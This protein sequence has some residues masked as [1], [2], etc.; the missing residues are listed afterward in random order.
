M[1][2]IAAPAGDAGTRASTPPRAIVVWPIA[3][4]GAAAA[5]TSVA[6]AL[7]NRSIGLEL[8]EPLVVALLH[9]S[10]TVAYVAC[11]LVAWVAR[12]TSRFGP[13][14]VVAGAVNFLTSLSWSTNE[15]VYTLGQTLDLVAP[16]VFLHAF[17]A[18]PTGRLRTRLERVVIGA[19][20]SIAVSFEIVRMLLGEFGPRNLLEVH[21][22]VALSHE[23]RRVQLVAI[24]AACLWGVVVLGVRRRRAGPPLRR[25]LDLLVEAF[26]LSLVLIAFLLLSLVVGTPVIAE[27]RWA[28]FV[29]LSLAP[30]AFLVGLLDARLARADVGGLVVELR[31]NPVPHELRDAVARALRDDSLELAFW[32][33]EY[34]VYADLDG[35]TVDVRAAGRA[36]T[37]I[38]RDDDSPVAALLHDP[39]LCDEPELLDAVAAA[40]AMAL[41]NARL[42]AELRARLDELRQS[43]ARIVEAGQKERQ[44]LERN[45]HDGAQQRLVA[46]S[47]ELSRLEGRLA[48]DAEAVAR[49]ERAQGEIAASLDALRELAHGLHPAVVS[50][51]GL[52]VALEELAA[53]APVP[54]TLTI[55]T[56]RLPEQLEVAAFYL[57]SESL[58][59]VG[60]YAEATAASIEVTRTASHLVVEIVDNGVGGADTER[61]TGLRGLADR[62]EALGGRLRVWSPPGRG[63]RVRAELPCA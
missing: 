2:S 15:V 54:V 22:N 38:E 36:V 43:R 37:L 41:E 23:V 63:T 34:G 18:F 6:L 53:R 39:S 50:A 19:A 44:R 25:P 26:A 48:H 30:V 52:E 58:A 28:T 31:S 62:V 3:V 46:L 42:H 32:L 16:V 35:R 57:V 45:L 33:P 17:L 12:P 24:A 60:K 4:A 27:L 21:E 5:A 7:S 61:G 14:M 20:Y 29:A 10:I 9:V 59:N 1:S 49:V 55:D 40:A 47:L 8:G 56:G 13:V 51:H 11:G